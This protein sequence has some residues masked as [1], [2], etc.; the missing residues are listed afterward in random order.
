MEG[1][2]WPSISIKGETVLLRILLSLVFAFLLVATSVVAVKTLQN[3]PIRIQYVS[4]SEEEKREINCLAQNIY[5]EA[6]REP[7]DGQ[8]AVA[9]VTL[10]RVKNQHFADTICGVVK[11]RTKTTCQ[12]TW[13]C[14]QN[15]AD[16]NRNNLYNDIRELAIYFY[17]NHSNMRDPS[18]GALFYHA[19]YVDPKWKNMI[20]TAYI[21]RH[22][23][24]S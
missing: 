18:R 23:W 11:Q 19:D 14:E 22:I 6:A 21:G 15:I 4:L 9:F 12:F 7:K 2:L 20:K 8:I 5:F 17:F 1:G 24:L 16:I 3:K 10:N 13:Y